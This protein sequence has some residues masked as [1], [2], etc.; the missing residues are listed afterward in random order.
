MLIMEF[1]GVEG[2]Q[3]PMIAYHS[4][5][6]LADAYV[7]CIRDYDVKKAFEAMKGLANDLDRKGKQLS[8]DYGFIPADLKGQSVS[9]TLE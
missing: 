9:R 4:L 2:D 3:P 1:D 5:S 6:V 7:K 8:L